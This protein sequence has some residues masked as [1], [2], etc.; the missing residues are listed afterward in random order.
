MQPPRD[1]GP[2]AAQSMVI[3]YVGRL[4]QTQKNVL[5]IPAILGHAIDRG[6]DLVLEVVG[7]GPDAIELE[8]RLRECGVRYVVHGRLGRDQTIAVMKRGDVLLMPSFYEGL[9]M[10]LLEAMSCGMT[11]IASRLP[12]STDAVVESGVNGMLIEPKDDGGFADAL[13]TLAK[14]RALLADMSRRAY[15]VVRERFSAKV[16]ASAYLN[17]IRECSKEAMKTPPSRT[18]AIDASLLGDFPNTPYAL[19]RA[20]RKSLRVL[21]LYPEPIHESRI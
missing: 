6:V 20:F 8:K 13:V 4:E 14:D 7:E 21:G 15:E 18:G 2:D 19:V 12:G 17:L 10:T 5:A 11:P 1:K 9:P 3:L 16:M